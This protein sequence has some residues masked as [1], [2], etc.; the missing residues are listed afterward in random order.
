MPSAGSLAAF[1]R[2]VVPGVASAHGAAGAEWVSDLVAQNPS[3]RPV[4]LRL[5]YASNRGTRD[6]ALTLGPGELRTFDDFPRTL[7]A[8]GES[9]GA[10]WIDHPAE[11]RPLVFALTRDRA[12]G[13]NAS[14][15]D[16]LSQNDAAEAGTPAG[17]LQ[18]VGARSGGTRRANVGAINV[19]MT[20]ARIRI[21][22]TAADGAPVGGALEWDIPEEKSWLLVDVEGKLGISLDGSVVLHVTPLRGRAVAYASVI[23]GLTGIHELV[24][25]LPVAR[26]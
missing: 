13:G 14:R 4:E 15:S 16:P 8:L 18:I 17:D 24:P 23:D 26:P 25:A 5:R 2:V 7:F 3:N 21:H 1:E 6:R 9:A 20:T 10:L 12:R 19:G 22:A 11:A